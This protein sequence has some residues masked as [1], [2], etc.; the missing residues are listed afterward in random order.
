MYS[1]IIIC[2]RLGRD[3]EMAYTKAGDNYATLAVAVNDKRKG[4]EETTW[5]RVTCW[6]KQAEFVTEYLKKGSTVLVDGRLK[7]SEYTNKQGEKKFSLDIDA[8]TVQAI[9][10]KN[11]NNQSPF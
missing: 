10:S 9:G 1:K 8:N 7:V 6:R 4:G 2:G 5:Y 3:P 11:E